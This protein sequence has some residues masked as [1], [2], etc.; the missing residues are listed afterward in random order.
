[1]QHILITGSN[2]GLGLELV[3]QLAQRGDHIIATCRR[4]TEAHQLQQ[5]AAAHPSQITILPLDTANPDSIAQA[6][7]AIRKK[8]DRLDLLINNAGINPPGVQALDQVTPELLLETLTT[9]AIGPL[10]IVK[11]CL[12]LLRAG[13]Q[14]RVMNVSTQIGSFW[15]KKFG[16]TYAY[17]SSKAAL[18]MITR[19]MAADLKR[20]GIITITLHPGWVQTDMGGRGAPLSP[21]ESARSLVALADSLK[22]SDNGKF[23]KWTGE[24]HPW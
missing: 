4:P 17:S 24:I 23:F 18:N 11:E 21:E 20:H 13:K 19:S 15:Y 12:P 22:M 1:M 7:E 16:G 14:P 8:N 5:L 9:N 6:G 10:M 3:H 2:R